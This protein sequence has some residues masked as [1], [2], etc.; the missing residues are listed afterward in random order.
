M[1]VL[2]RYKFWLNSQVNMLFLI[3]FLISLLSNKHKLNFSFLY[4]LISLVIHNQFWSSD[5]FEILLQC[6]LRLTQ[7]CF[8]KF[9][10][11]F[12]P[13]QP[14]TIIY[15]SKHTCNLSVLFSF[16]YKVYQNKCAALIDFSSILWNSAFCL[17]VRNS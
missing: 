7:K 10:L 4:A 6:S 9:E 1:F 11:Y 15:D 12:F 8:C 13:P 3:T 16:L 14:Q 17:T 2:F 5:S